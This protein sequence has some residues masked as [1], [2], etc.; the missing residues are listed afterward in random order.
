ME[1]YYR[2][3]GVWGVF[4]GFV[5]TRNEELTK[6]ALICDI[7]LGNIAYLYVS[8]NVRIGDT[9]VSVHGH[10]R[11]TEPETRLTWQR[12]VIIE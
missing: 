3:S 1:G 11:F 7:T 5:G 2:Y 6:V 4:F 10:R 12:Y 8:F 9:G